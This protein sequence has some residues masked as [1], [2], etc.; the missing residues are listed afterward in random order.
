MTLGK[1]INLE[2]ENH[3]LRKALEISKKILTEGEKHLEAAVQKKPIINFHPHSI[4]VTNKR[5]I[6]HQPHLFKA[7]FTDFLW[8]DLKNVHLIDRLF[9]STLVFQFSHGIIVADR[10]PKNQAKKVY[11]IAQEK[12]EEWVEK[13]RLRTIEENRAKSGANHII[14]GKDGKQHESDGDPQ[15]SIIRDKLLELQ[16]LLSDGLVTQDEYQIKKMELLKRM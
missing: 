16:A 10:L 4:V 7:T 12:E 13:R 9:G 14:I 11:A 5:V 8:K 6:K 15:T 1:S 2:Q 3:P